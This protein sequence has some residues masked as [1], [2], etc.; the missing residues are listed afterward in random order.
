VVIIPFR[1]LNPSNAEIK[2]FQTNLYN[3][4]HCILCVLSLLND[5]IRQKGFIVHQGCYDNGT[6]PMTLLII[7]FPLKEQL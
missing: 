3:L 6:H 7:N 2:Y 5:L 4:Y 1:G